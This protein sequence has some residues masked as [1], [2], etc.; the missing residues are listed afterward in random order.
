MNNGE[1]VREEIGNDRTEDT[2]K[3]QTLIEIRNE[4][5]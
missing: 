5:E 1:E 3:E 4:N 2:E